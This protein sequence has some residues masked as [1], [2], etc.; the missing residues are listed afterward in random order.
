M[1]RAEVDRIVLDPSFQVRLKMDAGT[2]RKY[3]D[4]MGA[5]STFTP[6]HLAN[7]DGAL[8]LLGIR[9]RNVV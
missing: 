3:A 7:V 6:I 1:F 8:I 5:G 2:V 4:A 9:S